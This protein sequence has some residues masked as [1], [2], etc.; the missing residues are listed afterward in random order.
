MKDKIKVVVTA[1]GIEYDT[2][3]TKIFPIFLLMLYP[4]FLHHNFV[5]LLIKMWSQPTL[6][7]HGMA[8]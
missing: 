1:E 4:C 3:N 8:L 6:L 7:E 5:A 2:M